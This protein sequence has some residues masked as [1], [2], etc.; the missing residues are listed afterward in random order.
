MAE[1]RP[2][3]LRQF[4]Y[5]L[6]ASRLDGLFFNIDRELQRRVAAAI[7]RS[8]K[9]SERQLTVLLVIFRFARNSYQSVHYL[10]ASFADSPPCR[11]SLFT[12]DHVYH[13]D[14]DYN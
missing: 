2:T 4:Y 1:E 7:Q 10:T 14:L 9:D 12:L 5:Q 6:V 3:P 13:L 8:D 11:I